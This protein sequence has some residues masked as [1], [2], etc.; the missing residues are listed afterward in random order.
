MKNFPTISP[1]RLRLA[2]VPMCI[3]FSACTTPAPTY[4]YQAAETDPVI[5]MESDYE[6]HTHFFV[7]TKNPAANRCDD[8]D[9]AGYLLKVN[10]IFLYDKSSKEINIRSA[11]NKPITVSAEHIFS[12]PGESRHCGPLLRTF[13]PLAG[14]RYVAK[15]NDLGKI[16]A[17]TVD[18]IDDKTQ[19][20]EAVPGTALPK[21]SK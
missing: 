18:R 2:L 12:D 10:S 21:C 13:T 5:S 8:F 11:A 6:L 7:N 16:C 15:M 4:K 20:R 14:G 9:R 17:L 3:L 1:S 19:A